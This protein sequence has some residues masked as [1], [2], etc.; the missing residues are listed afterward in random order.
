MMMGLVAFARDVE[1]AFEES[2][3]TKYGDEAIDL[4]LGGPSHEQIGD[5]P[6]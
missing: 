4:I 3:R 5:I 6:F 1:P 2:L